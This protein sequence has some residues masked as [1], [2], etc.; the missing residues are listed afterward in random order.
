MRLFFYA[1][2][3]HDEIHYLEECAEKYDFEY[4]LTSEYPSPDNLDLAKGYE[5]VSIITNPLGP[6]MLDRMKELGVKYITTR[7]IGYE[8][9][10]VVHAY[11]IGLKVAHVTYAPESVADYTIMMMLIACRKMPYIM[12]GATVQNFSLKGKIGREIS[13]STIGVLGTGNIGAT[14]V[15]H[16]SGFG[17]RI[18]MND[19]YEKDELRVY[20]NYVDKETIYKQSD[21]ITLHV[22]A[23]ADNY[24]MVDSK[25]ID[26]MK[27][28]VI[29]VNCARGSLI[30]TSALI[31]ALCSGK[32]GFAALDTIENEAGLYYLDR[33]GDILDNPDRA[34]LLSMPNVYLTPH[35]AF[36][37]ERTVS[38]MINN[39]CIGLLNFE[40]G[41]ENPFEVKRN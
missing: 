8:H 3:D 10:D 31:S 35:M 6:E 26:T 40:K 13:A 18:L 22:P 2:R 23:Y 28:G 17:C 16:L 27:D 1:L 30:D 29:I 11:S 32:V 19:V 12:Q 14:V 9:I 20:G 39:A 36:Y 21:I 38:D 5:A 25:A 4:G 24:H 7:S 15:K 37:T 41:I 33:S 34:V